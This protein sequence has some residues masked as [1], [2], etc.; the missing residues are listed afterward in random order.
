MRGAAGMPSSAGS[1]ATRRAISLQI[2]RT[3][4]T[5]IPAGSGSFRGRVTGPT[6]QEL[7]TRGPRVSPHATTTHQ[8]V[9]DGNA[10]IVLFGR[11]A[12]A[13]ADDQTGEHIG[14]SG[15]PGS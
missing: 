10:Q 2:G 8:A 14:G 9:A 5:V 7:L 3:W 6:G 1:P 11:D 15:L 4:S 13:L 12:D